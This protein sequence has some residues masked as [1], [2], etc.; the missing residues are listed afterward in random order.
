MYDETPNAQQIAALNDEFRARVGV[1]VFDPRVPGLV[2][3][4]RGIGALS[5]ADQIAVWFKVC[6][7]DAFTPDNDPHGEHDFGAI[8]LAGV[9]KIFWKIDYYAD[10][11]MTYGSEDP[12]DLAKTFR[13]LTIMLAEEY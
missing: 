13:V 1:P 3:M 9:G 4:T 2:L 10:A 12:A 7:F 5:P 8:T 6:D 11:S